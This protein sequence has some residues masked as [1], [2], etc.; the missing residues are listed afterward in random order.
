M[1]PY[2]NLNN[3]GATNLTLGK[4]EVAEVSVINNGYSGQYGQMAGSQVN[5]V[6]KSGTNQFHGNAV[7]YWAGSKLAA[8]DFFANQ[9]GTP[10]TFF[11]DNQWADSIGGPIWKN[12]TFFYFNNEGI[13]IILPSASTLI[14]VP[15]PQFEAATLANLNATGQSAQVP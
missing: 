8:N 3:S 9:S 7:W 11:N 2:L 15:S 6:T 1:D 4:N 14:K 12:K 13:R 10:K 5:A